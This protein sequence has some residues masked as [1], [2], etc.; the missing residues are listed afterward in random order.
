MYIYFMYVCMYIYIY[1][2]IYIHIYIYMYICARPCVLITERVRVSPIKLILDDL[3]FAT[4]QK[5]FILTLFE[6]TYTE[7]YSWI[8]RRLLY[9]YL[10]GILTYFF[11]NEFFYNEFDTITICK[12]FKSFNKRIVHFACGIVIV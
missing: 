11:Y 9:K 4:S 7:Y 1:I 5:N 3:S 2:Y 6:I 12:W 8:C 10:H